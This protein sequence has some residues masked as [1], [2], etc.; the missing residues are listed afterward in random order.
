MSHRAISLNTA[1]RL[2]LIITVTFNDWLW[3][4][5]G[6]TYFLVLLYRSFQ[7]MLL[8]GSLPLIWKVLIQKSWR[9]WDHPP[10]GGVPL[11][12]PHFWDPS[13]RPKKNF[14]QRFVPMVGKT[15]FHTF[16]Q[17]FFIFHISE[18]SALHAEHFRLHQKRTNNGHFGPHGF[19]WPL[20]FL[21]PPPERKIF[22]S[23]SPWWSEKLFSWMLPNIS[24]GTTKKN[25][26]KFRHFGDPEK[27]SVCSWR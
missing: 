14:L 21:P 17:N 25:S 16:D 10:G 9:G 27:N 8:L 7:K 15:G 23:T 12:P 24:F 13:P 1:L 2:G 19:N 18:I 11:D 4:E 20:S 22:F 26:P 5:S 6:V 3:G